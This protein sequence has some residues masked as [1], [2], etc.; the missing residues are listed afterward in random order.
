MNILQIFMDATCFVVIS[1]QYIPIK[2]NGWS[3]IYLII[4]IKQ[5]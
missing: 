2:F 5:Q 1:F 4:A 3:S